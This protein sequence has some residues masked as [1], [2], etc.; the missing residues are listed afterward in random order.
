MKVLVGTRRRH[1]SLRRFVWSS[2]PGQL[3]VLCPVQTQLLGVGGELPQ[4][5]PGQSEVIMVVTWPCVD[6]SQ[7][8]WSSSRCG[9]SECLFSPGQGSCGGE[10]CP[11]QR[12]AG[13]G[14]PRSW[15]LMMGS[16]VELQTNVKW[17]FRMISH[18]WAFSCLKAPTG[19]YC[20]DR[21]VLTHGK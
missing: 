12:V 13:G 11:W 10:P 19:A 14:V 5:H 16:L 4:S 7:L 20:L 1:K 9:S 3:R 15:T 17:R 8:T 18:P 6:Q 21:S 2:I